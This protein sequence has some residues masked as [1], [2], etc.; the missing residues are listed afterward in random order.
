MSLAR[1][2][3]AVGIPPVQIQNLNST[4]GQ[5]CKSAYSESRDDCCYSTYD[6]P[7][8]SPCKIGEIQ[9][10]PNWILGR[11]N[12]GPPSGEPCLT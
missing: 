9:Q 5:G 2:L 12:A 3:P 4:R 1:F 11:E 7:Q 8:G 10:G 6:C